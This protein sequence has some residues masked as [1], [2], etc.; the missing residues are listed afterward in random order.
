MK[1]PASL[2]PLYLELT[3]FQ[4]NMFLPKCGTTKEG[5]LKMKTSSEEFEA[6]WFSLTTFNTLLA[7]RLNKFNRFEIVCT[8]TIDENTLICSISDPPS[9]DNETAKKK[10]DF[11][12]FNSGHFTDTD[13]TF[14]ITFSTICT[15]AP[16]ESCRHLLGNSRTIILCAPDNTAKCS[17]IHI[18]QQK[19]LSNSDDNTANNFPCPSPTPNNSFTKSNTLPQNGGGFQR[20]A[21][22][23]SVL[24]QQGYI[25]LP[26]IEPQQYECLELSPLQCQSSPPLVQL[27]WNLSTTLQLTA[28]PKYRLLGKTGM[29]LLL[30]DDMPDTSRGI[31]VSWNTKKCNTFTICLPL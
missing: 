25:N 2:G 27:F 9:P 31:R 1:F 17:W 26:P 21:T 28:S 8:W 12:S 6:F 16:R 11:D 3:S 7:Y 13:I 20:S 24:S 4:G 15:L 30:G 14:Q 10:R 19:I 18:I 23:E 22:T 5:I 29:Y